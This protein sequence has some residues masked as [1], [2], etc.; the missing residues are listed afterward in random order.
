ENA[1]EKHRLREEVKSL[2]KQLDQFAETDLISISPKMQ[3]IR[4]IAKQV[5]DTDA[6]V[7]ISGEAG[8]GKEVVARY[9]HTLS[10]RRDR[11]LL[12]VNCAAL[13]NDFLE[14]ELFGFVG[15]A[16]L[17]A[18]SVRPGRFELAGKGSIQLDVI[19]E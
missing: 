19:G 6:S 12:R 9:I 16:V 5:A 10:K 1:L 14:S 17:V 13:P 18:S 7:L 2:R 3:R 15:G 4:E 11:P 8:V